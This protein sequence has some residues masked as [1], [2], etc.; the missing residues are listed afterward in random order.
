MPREYITAEQLPWTV[1]GRSSPVMTLT[2]ISPWG[3]VNGDATGRPV[4]E[5][6]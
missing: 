2:V 1:P 5:A 4:R 6:G 3:V